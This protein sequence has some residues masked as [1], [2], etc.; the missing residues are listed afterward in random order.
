[1]RALDVDV[2]DPADGEGAEGEE[3]GPDALE[4][5][6]FS[7]YAGRSDAFADEVVRIIRKTAVT[8]QPGDG[9][10]FVY[11]VEDVVK[12]RTGQTGLEAM[13]HFDYM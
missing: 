4:H 8:G 11:D 3:D 2:H 5:V 6:S 13:E 7:G 9:K 1:M 12:V 10:I